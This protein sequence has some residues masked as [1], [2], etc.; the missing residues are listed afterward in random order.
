VKLT[1]LA[2]A[3]IVLIG[4]I[5]FGS[6]GED[7]YGDTALT[8]TPVPTDGTLL[9][10]CIDPAGDVDYVMFAGIGGRR[11][12]I[13]TS[14]LS[15]GMDTV[16][17]LFSTDG[18][19]ILAVDDDSGGGGASRIEWTCPANGTYFAMVRHASATSGTG[20]YEL[21]L[22]VLQ[23]DDHGDGPT[24]ATP[25][26]SDGTAVP[27][28]LETKGDIDVFL[29]PAEAGYEYT[30]ETEDLSAGMDT[31]I[32]LLS[33]DGA[34]V[35][36]SDD[37]SGTGTASRISWTAP[38]GGTYFVRVKGKDDAVTGGYALVVSRRGY[39]D[40]HGNSP[41]DATPIAPGGN[42]ITG[43]IEV[44]GDVD[45]FSLAADPDAEYTISIA[46]GSLTLY[47]TDG[48][49]VLSE[50]DDELSWSAPAT[51]TYYL[52]VSA[53]APGPYTLI[54][55][56]VF[57]LKELGKFNSSGYALDVVVTDHLA[58][59]IV[60]VKGLLVIDVSDPTS[61]REI[62][63]YST[64]GYA[65]ALAISGKRAYI[66]DRG[67]GLAIIDVSD[68]TS[69][70]ELGVI[71]TPGSAQDVAIAGNYAY[72]ADFQSGLQVIDVSNP[73]AP[74]IV[75]S[76]ETRGYAQGVTVVDD[77]AL[78]AT[79]DVGIEVIDVS[80]PT[81]PVGVSELDLPGEVTGSV[82]SGELVYVAAG[83]RGIRIVSIADPTDPL[84]VG[85]IEGIGEVTGLFA[86]GGTLYS[87]DSTDG[88]STFS[89]ADPT[90]PRL[91]AGFDTPGSA[92]AIFADAERAYVADREEGL[93]II[94]LH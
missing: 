81:R 85:T 5:G 90:S 14:H 70:E 28:F 64:R 75:G 43:M 3:G 27:G 69:P 12:V 80:D 71:D 19:T 46:G 45:F 92:T 66:A 49:T 56:A 79:G 18:G 67:E 87:A 62:A 74:K 47:G 93:L 15:E 13:Q 32:D 44:E 34:S 59:L 6:A 77:V 58:Y 2:I 41:A 7:L 39:G 24:T 91:L 31:I 30:I 68:P 52:A 63:A 35:I 1:K 9:E 83:Y 11:Y 48:T 94:K 26:S 4:A 17:F 16:L 42:E 29:F 36:A 23:T 65:Q 20:C 40:D 61:P 22:S 54:L 10:G 21:S 72:V 25:I 88:I 53:G 38:A 57:R 73:R 60:G 82:A 78:V 50:T 86:S 8:A 76:W 89:I 55:S 51:G 37:D 33:P 84:E